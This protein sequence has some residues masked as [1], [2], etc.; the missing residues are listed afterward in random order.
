M[1]FDKNPKQILLIILLSGAIIPTIYY[2][3][4]LQDVMPY[5][6]SYLAMDWIQQIT[7]NGRYHAEYTPLLIIGGA[8]LFL[9]LALSSWKER[10]RT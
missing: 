1:N 2:P 8:L 9:L 5:I 10:A 6:I 3:P 7:L 4:F